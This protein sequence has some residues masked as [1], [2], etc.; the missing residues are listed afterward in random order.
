MHDGR[1]LLGHA[2]CRLVE[3]KAPLWVYVLSLYCCLC[4]VGRR[5]QIWSAAAVA[6]KHCLH[7]VFTKVSLSFS[8][9]PPASLALSLPLN[10]KHWLSSPSVKIWQAVSPAV[11]TLTQTVKY[12]LYTPKGDDELLCGPFCIERHRRR[13]LAGTCC[14]LPLYIE[15][16]YCS[17]WSP[18][19]TTECYWRPQQGRG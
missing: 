17:S 1:L 8:L 12:Y 18:I 7:F 9:P 13:H 5:K 10:G 19:A 11:H 2:T 6:G 16:S 4:P 15:I 3:V 14:H